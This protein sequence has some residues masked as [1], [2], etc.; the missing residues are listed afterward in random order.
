MTR[1]EKMPKLSIPSITVI[2]ER[3]YDSLF[4][5]EIELQKDN[6][7]DGFMEI[8]NYFEPNHEICFSGRTSHESYN[9]VR[10]TVNGLEIKTAYHGCYGTWQK[11]TFDE[12]LDHLRECIPQR[13]C[14]QDLRK[15]LY[16]IKKDK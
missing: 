4:E 14:Q 9:E 16:W 8:L 5:Y 2:S 3:E 6:E 1:N 12:A 15:G 11:A 10:A 13:E 7:I